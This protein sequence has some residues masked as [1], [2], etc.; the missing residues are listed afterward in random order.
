VLSPA[1]GPGVATDDARQRRFWRLTLLACFARAVRVR[2]GSR[3]KV[4]FRFAALAAFLTLRLA[5][6]F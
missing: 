6:A 3:L 4:F 2:F 5:A 1:K